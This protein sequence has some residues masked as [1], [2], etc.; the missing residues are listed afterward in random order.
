MRLH[1]AV[2]AAML[3]G[4]GAASADPTTLIF[5]THEPADA[6][7]YAGTWKPWAEKVVADSHGAL[8]IDNRPQGFTK[9]P[10]EHLALVLSGKADIAFIVLPNYPDRFRDQDAFMQPGMLANATEASVA[11]TRMQQKGLLTGFENLVPLAVLVAAP[12]VAHSTYPVRLPEDLNGKRWNTNA[13]LTIAL[14]A[15]LGAQMSEHLRD[16]ARR[17]DPRR[18]RV[19]R[20]RRRLGRLQHLRHAEGRP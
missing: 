9:D 10:I 14:F 6:F 20:R 1:L 17:Q 15:R 8:V 19:R 11:A 12:S 2:L 7:V 16:A 13:R 3:W 5:A 18:S 4:V